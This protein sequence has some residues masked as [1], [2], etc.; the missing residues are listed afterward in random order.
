[1]DMDIPRN[2]ELRIIHDSEKS[3]P[4]TVHCTVLPLDQPFNPSF[5]EATLHF[6]TVLHTLEH[7]L[8]LP[9]SSL[10]GIMDDYVKSGSS[11]SRLTT[12]PAKLRDAGLLV[13]N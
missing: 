3:E 2:F 10:I 1:M 4:N 5:S 9:D 7:V 12:T 8:G 11:R 6:E 13:G